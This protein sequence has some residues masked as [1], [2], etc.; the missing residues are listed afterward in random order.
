MRNKMKTAIVSALLTATLLIGTVMSP[1]SAPQKAQAAGKAYGA[2]LKLNNNIKL[3]KTKTFVKTGIYKENTFYPKAQKIDVKYTISCK[4]KS[5]GKKY[6]VTYKVKYNYTGDPQ[7]SNADKIWYDDWFWGY[8][9]PY[10]FYTVFDYKT[11]MSLEAK[12]KLGVKVKGSKWKSSYYP[13]QYYTYTGALAGEYKK[14][15]CWFSNC[16]T[17]S[18]SFTVTY[19]KKCKNIVVGIGFANRAEVPSE[20]TTEPDNQYWTGKKT[21]YGKTSYYKK[22]KK[23]MSYMRLNK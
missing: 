16:K 11:G 19:P 12:N 14:E 4:R 15:D 13:K 22:G 18:Y 7:I 8:T 1:V 5:V 9:C 10:A 2:R 23:T 3:N 21:P 6:K 17:M 20:L